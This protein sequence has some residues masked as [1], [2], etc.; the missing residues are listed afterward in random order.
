M[1]RCLHK[2]LPS[3]HLSSSLPILPSLSSFVAVT[4][5]HF[6]LK[7]LSHIR[8]MP[9]KS[10]RERSEQRPSEGSLKESFQVYELNKITH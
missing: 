3:S 9:A 4:P 5:F 6:L 10:L 1:S 8:I 7:G 2:V